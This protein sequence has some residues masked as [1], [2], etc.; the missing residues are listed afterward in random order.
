MLL[1]PPSTQSA[2]SLLLCQ[3]MKDLLRLSSWSSPMVR[4]TPA[5][6]LRRNKLRPWLSIKEMFISGSLYSSVL[7]SMPLVKGNLLVSQDRIALATM[8][9]GAERT[10][11]IVPVSYTHLTLPTSD[12][13]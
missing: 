4:K 2:P 3:R 6:L 12:L 10:N 5:R 1:E 9:L 8:Q 11:C 7:T 13:V